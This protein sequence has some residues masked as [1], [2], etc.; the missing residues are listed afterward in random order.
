MQTRLGLAIQLLFVDLYLTMQTD[1]GPAL[2][3]RRSDACICWLTGCNQQTSTSHTHLWEEVVC[4]V[5]DCVS[6]QLLFCLPAQSVQ[7]SISQT[8]N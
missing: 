1:Q 2:L 8:N 7:I 3:Q 4:N 5:A 6:S